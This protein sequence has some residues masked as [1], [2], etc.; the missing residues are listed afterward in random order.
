MTD[1]LIK[2]TIALVAFLV[3]YHLILEG[4]KMHQFNRFYL[5]F[6][7]VI[8]L[9]IP[10]I[11]FEIIKE[12]PADFSN[13]I[14]FDPA[15]ITMQKAGETTNYKAV[16]LWSLYAL[17]TLILTIR[18]GR[19]IS[20][21]LSKSSSNPIL[22]FKNAK[23]ILVPEKIVPHTFLNYIFINYDDYQ[24]QNIEEELYIHE[25]VHVTQKHT[26]DILFIE[27]L[28]II[29]WYNPIF[30]LYKKSIQLNHEFLADQEIV[31]KYDN[32]PFYQSLLLK[33]GNG[34]Q[35]VYLASNLNYLV[36]K[37]RLIMMKKTTS[38]KIAFI[39]KIAIVPVVGILTA[40][41][42]VK[43]IAQ[44]TKIDKKTDTVKH[45]T[46]PEKPYSK[47]TVVFK[48]E[49]K[50]ESAPEKIK[51][52]TFSSL[53]EKTDVAQK[54]VSFEAMEDTA[55]VKSEPQFPGGIEEFYKF[56]GKNFKT[57]SEITKN[58]IKAKVFIQFMIEKDG[59]LSEFKIVKDPGYDVGDEAIR[60]LKLSPN[61][62]PGT[63]DGKPVRVLYT[64]PIM[65]QSKE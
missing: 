32:V 31:E 39:K 43:T 14:T 21:I 62:I 3:F 30:I 11:S 19:N 51:F 5:L 9:V 26:F 20:K 29:F 37:K 24:S 56:I 52:T 2:S 12:I 38:K 50:Q 7:I 47:T 36:T 41:L 61:W 25:L 46:E 59:S 23:L 18:F 33:T 8:S 54:S 64:L 34:N 22:N 53:N 63:E 4:E 16:F 55:A 17:V 60:V 40:F 13:K 15:Q 58:K 65:V 57:P 1:F 35:T 45:G 10:F 6:S 27:F 44:Q 49:K 42:C 48:E 28:K